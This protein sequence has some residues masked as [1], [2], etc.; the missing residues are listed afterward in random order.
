MSERATT[1]ETPMAH[2]TLKHIF[3]QSS[4]APESRTSRVE[5]V[6]PAYVVVNRDG[7]VAGRSWGPETQPIKA[8]LDSMLKS[9]PAAE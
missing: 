3:D 9:R 6:L 8:T 1:R 5:F 2:G 4:T 7:R